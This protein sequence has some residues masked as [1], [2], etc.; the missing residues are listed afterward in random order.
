MAKGT[1]IRVNDEAL[2]ILKKLK[3]DHMLRDYSAAIVLMD[4]KEV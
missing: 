4:K 3:E 1:Q 2:E